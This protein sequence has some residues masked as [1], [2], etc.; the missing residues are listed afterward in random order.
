MRDWAAKKGQNVNET[1]N[2]GVYLIYQ[3]RNS[4][5]QGHVYAFNSW[6]STW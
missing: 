5:G 3:E 1:K 6:E 4:N 2:D